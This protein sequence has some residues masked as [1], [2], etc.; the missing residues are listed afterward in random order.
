[1]EAVLSENPALNHASFR[2]LNLF[3]DKIYVITIARAGHRREKLGPLLK[4]LNY[5]FFWGTDKNILESNKALLNELYSEEKARMLHRYGKPMITGH[6]AC[7][8]SHRNVYEDIIKNNYRNALI[9]EDDVV[10]DKYG[11]LRI[12]EMLFSLPLD[13]ELLY[14]GYNKN[15]RRHAANLLK[16]GFY[17]ILSSL[18]LLKWNSTM[19]K[20]LHARPFSQHLNR[21]GYHDFT[22]AYAISQSGARK[23]MTVQTPIAFNADTAL[24]WAVTNELLNAFITVPQVFLQ[25]VQISPQTYQSLI[26]D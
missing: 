26:D 2:E 17:H 18:G 8:L 21:A 3:F 13:W 15:T 14:L 9:L 25:E 6:I 23:M 16:Q 24:S 7:S 20:N 11:L 10:P 1:M 5:S 12:S 19:I 4:G 22:H